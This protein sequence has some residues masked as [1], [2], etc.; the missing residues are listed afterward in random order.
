MQDELLKGG[1]GSGP[2]G[3]QA[4]HGGSPQYHDAIAAGKTASE[5]SRKAD[6]SGTSKDHLD[7]A[8]ANQQAA[9]AHYT[10][11]G[12]SKTESD[13]TFHTKAGDTHQRS[14]M[15]HHSKHLD[16]EAATKKSLQSEDLIK[17]L[18]SIMHKGDPGSGPQGGQGERAAQATKEANTATDKVA[19]SGGANNHR[20]AADANIVAEHANRAAGNKD[21]ADKHSRQ[22]NFHYANALQ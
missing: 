3:G 1:P 20:K 4:S 22:A 15:E 8:I 21:Q 9:G 17:G 18:H 14:Q 10:A 5:A 13:R 7:A 16:A 19:R 11:A 2:Q 12:Y 6:K